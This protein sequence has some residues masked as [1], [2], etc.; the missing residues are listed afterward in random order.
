MRLFPDLAKTDGFESQLLTPAAQSA[1]K[2]NQ[3]AEK[4]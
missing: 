4:T 3:E 1:V 2:L